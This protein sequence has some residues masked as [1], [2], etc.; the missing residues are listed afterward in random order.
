MAD[1]AF[2]VAGSPGKIAFIEKTVNSETVYVPYVQLNGASVVV[3]S[4][5][6]TAAALNGT[7]AKTTTTTISGA[8]VMGNDGTNE[9]LI[10][11]GAGTAATALRVELPTDGT[12]KV[13][14]N[15][16]SAIV[17]KVGIDQTTPGTT[18]GVQVNAALPA[19]TNL[20]GNVGHGK[21]IKNYSASITSDTDIVAAVASKRIKVIAYSIINQDNTADT[22]I[23]KSNGTSGTELWRVYLRGPDANTPFGA[24]LSIPAPSFLFATVAGEKLTVDVSS[25]ATLHISITYFDDDNS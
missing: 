13:G 9:I 16:G 21:T 20:I 11:S 10:S 23:F 3:D 2:K 4:E 5:F 8:C 15:A 25:G 7:W 17:G 14:L 19:G 18:N 12:G 22:V 24:N 6:P 1:T